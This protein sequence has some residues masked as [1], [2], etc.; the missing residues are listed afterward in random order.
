MTKVF[1][2]RDH[3]NFQERA[4]TRAFG[5]FLGKCSKDI[6]KIQLECTRDKHGAFENSRTHQIQN[7]FSD[8][9]SK[10][11]IGTKIW[12]DSIFGYTEI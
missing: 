6:D 9:V 1:R 7:L 10:M 12:Y 5:N 4:Y 2:K 3:W 8:F 11:L